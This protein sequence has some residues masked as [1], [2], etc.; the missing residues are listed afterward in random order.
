[1]PVRFFL[2]KSFFTHL[3]LS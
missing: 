2:E 3:F 1:M